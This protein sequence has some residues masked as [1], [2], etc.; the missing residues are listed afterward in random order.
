MARTRYARLARVDLYE[1][2]DFYTREASAEVAERFYADVDAA[3]RNAL[4]HPR[5]G[6]IYLRNVRRTRC[7]SFPYYVYYHPITDGIRIVAVGHQK[8]RPD[9]WRD[10]LR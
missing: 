9:H 8:R 4:T 2:A 3:V 7:H 10:R 5:I 1:A 6:S